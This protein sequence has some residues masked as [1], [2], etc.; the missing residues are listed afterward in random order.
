MRDWQ[1]STI[2]I[3]VILILAWSTWQWPVLVFVWRTLFCLVL[4]I[5]VFA[6]VWFK[7]GMDLGEKIVI[8]IITTVMMVLI[9]LG[10]GGAEKDE[11]WYRP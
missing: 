7:E 2:V 5:I 1:L 10:L 4:W 11:P 3:L 8:M 9:I 6:G